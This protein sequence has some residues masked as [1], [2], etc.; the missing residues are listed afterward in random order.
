MF[1]RSFLHTA[2]VLALGLM[3]MTIRAQQ[4]NTIDRQRERDEIVRL[5]AKAA[6]AAEIE[7]KEGKEDLGSLAPEPQQQDFMVASTTRIEWDSN[8]LLLSTDARDSMLTSENL[9]LS[10]HRPIAPRWSVSSEINQSFFW[11]ESF[12]SN[13]FMGQSFNADINYDF[14]DGPHLS[15]GP[16]LYRYENSN[17][18]NQLI[19]S[20]GVHLGAD[21]GVKF[22]NGKSALFYGYRIDVECTDPGMFDRQQ[23][24]FFLGW[25]QTLIPSL[26]NVQGFYRFAYSDYLSV[27]RTD[28]NNLIGVNFLYRIHKNFALSTSCSYNWNASTLPTADYRNF[29]VGIS[30]SGMYSF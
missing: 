4:S 18:S 14:S 8:A 3:Q 27:A 26:L 6:A 25:N 29:A 24:Q 1:K 13:D 16:G 12:P 2:I 10:Y 11:Y 30:L 15:F 17:Q 23:H 19:Q 20:A 21:H 28:R 5:E 22:F 9:T 7:A